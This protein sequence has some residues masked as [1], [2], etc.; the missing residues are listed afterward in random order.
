MTSVAQELV[1]FL[2][3]KKD[4]QQATVVALSGDLGAGKTTLSQQVALLLGVSHS[5]TSPTFVIM[6]QYKTTDASWSQLV[7]I[8]AY[9]LQNEQ[10][11]L[12]LGWNSLL[13]DPQNLILIEWPERVSEVIPKDAVFV[14]LKHKTETTREISY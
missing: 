12:T 8:D 7:H 10:E 4:T 14:T 3:S 11:I 2:R 6:K 9:R 13:Q 1:D 5:V